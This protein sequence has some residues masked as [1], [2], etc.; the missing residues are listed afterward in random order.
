MKIGDKAYYLLSGYTVSDSWAIKVYEVEIVKLNPIH[1]NWEYKV[2]F[3]R[4]VYGSYY[5]VRKNEIRTIIDLY[6][7]INEAKNATKGRILDHAFSPD[8]AYDKFHDLKKLIT[9]MYKAK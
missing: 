9:T 6:K 4:P 7:T 5:S 8:T 2:M 1:V 3:L